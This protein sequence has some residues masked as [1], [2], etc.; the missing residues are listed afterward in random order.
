[1]WQVVSGTANLRNDCDLSVIAGQVGRDR[2][3]RAA[4][5]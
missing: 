3:V 5:T 4:M 1:M 2:I